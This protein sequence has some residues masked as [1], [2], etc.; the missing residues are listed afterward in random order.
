[1][2]QFSF[3]LSP[4]VKRNDCNKMNAESI[5]I[6]SRRD[7]NVRSVV[8]SLGD[9]INHINN[10]FPFMPNSET[11]Q[12]RQISVTFFSYFDSVFSKYSAIGCVRTQNERCIFASCHRGGCTMLHM[13]HVYEF[14][15]QRIEVVSIQTTTTAHQKRH[16]ERKFKRIMGKVGC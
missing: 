3:Q 9:F 14:Y 1:M 7:L 6:F 16:I 11:Q 4:Y 12:I 8:L 5:C 2:Q 15:V 13:P 10:I